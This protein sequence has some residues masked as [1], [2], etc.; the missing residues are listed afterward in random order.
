MGIELLSIPFSHLRCKRMNE[1]KYIRKFDFQNKM[2][3]RQS[4]QIESLKSQI[5]TLKLKCEEKDKIINSVESL[6]KELT[7]SIE[8]HRELRNEYENLVKELRIMKKVMDET[9]YKGRWRLIK[10]LIK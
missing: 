3:S 2:I 1:K 4:E 9:V 5:E 10:F 7:E 6:R 8:K